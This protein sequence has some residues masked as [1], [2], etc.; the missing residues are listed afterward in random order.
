VTRI[1]IHSHFISPDFADHLGERH[2]LPMIER[3]DGRRLIR[4]APGLVVPVIGKMTNLDEKLEDIDELGVDFTVLSHAI[5]GPEV[6]G[7]AEAEEWSR[8]INDYLASLIGRAPERISA[9]GMIGFGD[10]DLSRA[11]MDRCVNVLGFCGFQLY[12]NVLGQP[13]DSDR[14]LEVIGYAAELDVPLNLHPTVPMNT[15]G[16]EDLT[17]LTGLGFVTDTSLNTLRL[18]LSGI[19]DRYPGLNLIVPHVGGVL[20]YI[21]GRV[22]A[23]SGGGHIQAGRVDLEH[24]IGHYLR[25]L[26]VDTVTGDVTALRCAYELLGPERLLYGTDHPFANYRQAAEIVDQLGLPE[27]EQKMVYSEN[28]RRLLRLP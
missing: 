5:P 2:S 7:G 9:W 18:I 16:M 3:R 26:Y 21:H 15:V 20:P 24:P 22:A 8:R 11:E 23:H 27:N 13:L 28:T 12:S 17:V 19:F 4:S 25:K 14:I 10:P 1:D 6:L